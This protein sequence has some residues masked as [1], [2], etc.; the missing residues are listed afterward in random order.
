MDQ[1]ELQKNIGLYYSKLP[2]DIQRKF[3]SME[4]LKT[5][6][7]I[8]SKYSLTDKQIQI[9]GTETTLAL[10]GVLHLGEYGQILAKELELKDDVLQNVLA[11]INT[12]IFREITPKLNEAFNKNNQP[13]KKE[14][15][16]VMTPGLE[17][18]LEELPVYVKE[19]VNKSNYGEELFKIAKAKG[20]S[21]TEIGELE[22]ITTDLIDGK[23]SP[24]KLESTVEGIL[25]FDKDKSTALVSE[26]NEK[27]LKNIRRNMMSASEPVSTHAPKYTKPESSEEIFK[28]AGMEILQSTPELKSGT[29][30]ES[31]LAEP[32]KIPST[33]T[34]YSIANMSKNT[35]A[36]SGAPT[37]VEPPKAEPQKAPV[38]YGKQDPYRM[39]VE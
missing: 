37:K 3:S 28:K 35:Q 15:E 19:A 5:L 21:I 29:I 20:L 11:E 39:P 8:S 9:L 12:E 23:L 22:K 36:D 18:K 16:N 7:G 25:R 30:S 34:E 17:K 26:I 31:K 33:K 4:W 24:D 32:F 6:E 27:I 2:E 13:D 10:L 38:S 1:E 14:G